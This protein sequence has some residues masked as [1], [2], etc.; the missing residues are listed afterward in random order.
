[1]FGENFNTH[2]RTDEPFLRFPERQERKANR[3]GWLTLYPDCRNFDSIAGRIV[4]A[5]ETFW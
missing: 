1:M 5:S 3:L 4:Y 2:D